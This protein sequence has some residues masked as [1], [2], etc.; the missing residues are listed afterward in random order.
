MLPS[1]S[2]AIAADGPDFYL[3]HPI[4]QTPSRWACRGQPS[5][6][7]SSDST[8]PLTK[9]GSDI[10]EGIG[11]PTDRSSKLIPR[12]LGRCRQEIQ[13]VHLVPHMRQIVS[14]VGDW[15]FLFRKRQSHA[16]S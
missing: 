12:R 8:R 9:I 16:G 3:S 14:P 5:N 10:R 13:K 15:S 4:P 6:C 11:V 2:H 7:V 1:L